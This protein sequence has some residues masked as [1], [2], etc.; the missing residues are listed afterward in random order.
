MQHNKMIVTCRRVWY[1]EEKEECSVKKIL[2][3]VFS[4]L[5]LAG[6][7]SPTPVEENADPV[8]LLRQRADELEEE[9]GLTIKIG[10]ECQREFDSFTAARVSGYDRVNSA[11]DKLEKALSAYP[12][13]FFRQIHYDSI[14][15]IEIQL[16]GGLRAT[17]ERAGGSYAAFVQ[18]AS[19]HYM[20]VADVFS[21]T[22]KSYYHEFSHIIDSYLAWDAENRE[23]ALYSEDGWMERNPSGFAYV[24]SYSAEPESDPYP[25]YFVDT[26]SMISATEDRARVLEYAM[27]SDGLVFGENPPLK[28]KLHYYCECIRDAFDTQGWPETTLW[29]QY[30]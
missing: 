3:L 23:G 15:S 5:F 29:E 13:G 17:D 7:Q 9:Y 2:I 22:Q 11:L 28:E 19:D 16:V 4:L 24:G 25:G 18:P 1:N 27:A 6:C 30:L 12:E 8:A 20:L 26:Y 14:Q 21:A 10:D